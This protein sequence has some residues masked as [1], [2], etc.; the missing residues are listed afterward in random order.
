MIRAFIAVGVPEAIQQRIAERS[1]P[2]RK[3]L[4]KTV[5][6][7]PTDHIHLTL[8]F[9]SETT[10]TSLDTLIAE[11]ERACA[12]RSPFT[13]EVG[14]WGCFPNGRRPRVLW[15]G[16]K[17]E[18]SL[19][20]LQRAVEDGAVQVGYEAEDKPF[21]PHVTIGRVRDRLPTT[22][23]SGVGAML[24]RADNEWVEVVRVESIR[25]YRSDLYADGARHTVLA[26]LPLKG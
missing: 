17:A 16:I 10:G 19:L 24:L 23:R 18:P 7:T 6:W 11:L 22:V 20:T 26:E 2:F 9:L 13:L 8:K 1:E 5:R 14:G 15:A 21:T 3:E 4:G 25:V 12:E